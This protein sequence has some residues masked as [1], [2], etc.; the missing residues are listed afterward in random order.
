MPATAPPL[1]RGRDRSRTWPC[2]CASRFSPSRRHAPCA[3][4]IANKEAGRNPVKTIGDTHFLFICVSGMYAVAVTTGN[5][6]CATCFQFLHQVVNLFK[7]YFG[8]FS[9]E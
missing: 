8:D 2:L 4:V 7:G 3:Q 6:Q 5:P 1:A 9:E